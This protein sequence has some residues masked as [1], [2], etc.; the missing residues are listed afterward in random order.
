MTDKEYRQQVNVLL[1][2]LEYDLNTAN[3]VCCPDDSSAMA[4]S[5]GVYE[6]CLSQARQHILWFRER[7]ENDE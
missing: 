6:E 3:S 4:F 2:L 5:L 1:T 7:T